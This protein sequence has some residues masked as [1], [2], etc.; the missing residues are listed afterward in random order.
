VRSPLAG[1][2]CR[3]YLVFQ[4]TFKYIDH[5]RFVDSRTRKFHH[6]KLLFLWKYENNHALRAFLDPGNTALQTYDFM[7][8]EHIVDPMS[9]SW[10]SSSLTAG[11]IRKVPYRQASAGRSSTPFVRPRLSCCSTAPDFRTTLSE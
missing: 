7:F 6:I 8:S 9:P 3:E 10:R 5:R 11:L 1:S 2:F 4:V